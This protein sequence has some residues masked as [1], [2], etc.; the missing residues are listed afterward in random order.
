MKPFLPLFVLF[1][2]PFGREPGS[3]RGDGDLPEQKVSDRRERDKHVGARAL[4]SS[5]NQ[6]I[7]KAWFVCS[8]PFP[9]VITIANATANVYRGQSLSVNGKRFGG[10]YFLMVLICIL[11][12]PK[13]CPPLPYPR[14]VSKPPHHFPPAPAERPMYISIIK[15]QKK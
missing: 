13:A 10:F 2:C 8:F 15:V 5:S 3:A 7:P 6:R 1:V 4:M 9:I 11:L 12:L 14:F